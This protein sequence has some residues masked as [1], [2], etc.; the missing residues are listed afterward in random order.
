MQPFV[1]ILYKTQRTYDAVA[2]PHRRYITLLGPECGQLQ[3]LLRQDIPL[4]GSHFLHQNVADLA[5]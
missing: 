2:W 4:T 5:I 1:N 3:D